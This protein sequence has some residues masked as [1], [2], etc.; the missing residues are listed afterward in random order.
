MANKSAMQHNFG[1]K[2][3]KQ[4]VLR[5]SKRKYDYEKRKKQATPRWAN[6]FK[7]N[8][9]YRN[10]SKLNK[11]DGKNTWHVDHEFPLKYRG[12]DGEEGSGLHIHQN[13]N[14]VPRD[15]NLK[16]SNKFVTGG[17]VDV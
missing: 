5:V 7:I 8:A 1:L 11:R 13:L 14:V 2:K 6:H 4:N 16:K 12:E 17:L 10:A 9:I 15:V 3:I